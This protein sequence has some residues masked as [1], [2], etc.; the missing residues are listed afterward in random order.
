M[1]KIGRRRRGGEFTTLRPQ[2]GTTVGKKS[3]QFLQISLIYQLIGGGNRID[4]TPAATDNKP[5]V[6]T[7]DLILPIAT[8]FHYLSTN[9]GGGN[10]LTALQ[11]P[12]KGS[13]G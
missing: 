3:Y 13:R 7:S 5:Q 8:N 2:R 1:T 11:Q 6:T 4:C 12:Q 9:R 10:E